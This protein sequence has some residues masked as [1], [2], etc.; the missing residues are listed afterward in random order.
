VPRGSDGRSRP[1]SDAER[2]AL[3]LAE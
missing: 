2:I 3:E 1:L